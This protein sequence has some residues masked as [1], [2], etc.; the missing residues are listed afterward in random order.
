MRTAALWIVFWSLV[1]LGGS[2]VGYERIVQGQAAGNPRPLDAYRSPVDLALSPGGQRVLTANHTSDSVSLVDLQ[3]GKVLEEQP[4]GRKPAAVACS[5][6][7][8]A[9]SKDFAKSATAT[10]SC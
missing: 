4:C 5:R 8:K 3:H 1:C 10:A 2:L 7:R 9:I 6:L